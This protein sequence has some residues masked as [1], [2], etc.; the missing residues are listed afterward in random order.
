MIAAEYL[1]EALIRPVLIQSSTGILTVTARRRYRKA[2]EDGP[3]AG[4]PSV[5]F[6]SER[7]IIARQGYE[8]GFVKNSGL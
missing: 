8:T 1:P 2:A 6:F 3:D 4:L 7:R 5:H